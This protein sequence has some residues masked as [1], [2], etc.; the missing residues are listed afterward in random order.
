MARRRRKK[1]WAR[2]LLLI[3]G[4]CLTPTSLAVLFSAAAELGGLAGQRGGTQFFLGGAAGYT[5][6][7]ILQLLRLRRAYVFAHE[8]T[9]ALAAW[10][11]GG[12]VYSFVVGKEG[13]HVDLSHSSV[14]I[15]LAPYVFPLYAL[16]VVG[17]YRVLLWVGPPAHAQ[18][19]F[20]ALMGAVLAF[21]VAHTVESLWTTHQSDLDQVGFSMSM[22]LIVGLNGLLLL[23]ALKCLF[24]EQVALSSS[25][26]RVGEV[27]QAFWGGIGYWL[28]HGWEAIT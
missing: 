18:V 27:T 23:G 24:P 7:H 9:H 22:A 21:H 26:A 12:K 14:F 10:M 11:S 13:G 6:L 25:I 28:R 15:A 19:A 20:L 3:A 17:A 2:L 16:C 1:H 4:V 5:F 8:F